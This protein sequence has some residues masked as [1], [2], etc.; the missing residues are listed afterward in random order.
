MSFHVPGDLL[1]VQHLHLS[2]ADHNVETLTQARI[3][4]VRVGDLRRLAEA[5]PAINV[6]LWRDAL[7]DASIFREW[8]LNVG[9]RGSKARI[10]HMLCE[11]AIRCST[12]GLS[13]P[14][15]LHI[16]MTQEQ[17]ADATGLTTVHVNRSLRAL[18]H[19]GAIGGDG[20]KFV[21]TDWARLEEIA[22]FHAGYLHQA[23]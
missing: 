19:D 7:I 14:E 13:A 3:A 1:D 4:W 12:A 20:R 9:R 6:A 23:A 10:A 18:R 8:V 16:P 11:F 15:G 21:I 17:I 2:S 22:G 5:H